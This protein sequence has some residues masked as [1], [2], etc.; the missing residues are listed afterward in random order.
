MALSTKHVLLLSC[1][2]IPCAWPRSATAQW[3]PGGVPVNQAANDQMACTLAPDGTAGAIITW[4]DFRA[5]NRSDI[6]AQHILASGVTDPAWPAEGR[7][8]CT[9]TGDQV[10]P[11]IVSDD[12]GGAII[13][14]FDFRG[15]ATADI[16]AQRV[17]A[18]GAVDP[19]WPADGSELCTAAGDQ[20]QP[21][22]ETD[23]AGGAI[24]TWFDQRGTDL[25][26]YAQR[27]LASGIVDPTWPSNGR[28]LCTASG[29]QSNAALVTDG[30]GGA[31]VTWFDLRGSNN[32]IYV[33]RVLASGALDPAWPVDGRALCTAAGD[34]WDPT[35]TSDGAS[36]AIVTWFDHRDG[37]TPDIYAH[38]VLASGAVDPAW[39]VGG[40]D[41]CL[42]NGDQLDPTIASDGAGG[43]IVTWFDLRGGSSPDIYAQRVLASGAVD[44]SWPL[45]GLALC[46]AAGDQ[47]DPTIV[48]D[49]ANGAIVAW[50]D[51]RD[52]PGSDIYAQH[53]LA[54]GAVDPPWPVNGRALCIAANDQHDP[55]IISDGAGGALVSWIDFRDGSKSDVYAQRVRS[56]GAIVGVHPFEGHRFKLFQP[57]PN[58]GHSAI[59][60]TFQLPSSR[61]V[62]IQVLDLA[63]RRVRDLVVELEYP[64]GT[65]SIRW[66]G[67]DA[68]GTPVASGVYLIRMSVGIESLTRRVVLFQ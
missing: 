65:H 32:D 33:Q 48:S 28:A 1:L 58:P 16:Y 7:A 6:Y 55:V 56:N 64:A 36:G 54:S 44:P 63:G 60:L 37:P 12:A 46:S 30:A 18:S 26:I 51:F 23:G 40:R 27:V 24:V 10:D 2:S 22:I 5:G 39:P 20:Q 50:F 9:A 47:L 17:M 66:D 21:K 59:V 19:A 45:N 11:T 25:D 29:D 67:R 14:W 41:L 53:V 8:I 34:Q 3:I 38:R 13:T 43:A 52:G 35:I 57:S 31:I 42:A 4:A 62:D 49:G 61:R 68:A 15:G